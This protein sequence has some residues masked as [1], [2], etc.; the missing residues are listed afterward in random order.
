[1]FAEMAELL[2]FP[3]EEAK[4]RLFGGTFPPPLGKIKFS[5]AGL[6]GETLL[7]AEGRFPAFGPVGTLSVELPELLRLAL[8]K[9]RRR[10]AAL[11]LLFVE[12]IKGETMPLPL[13]GKPALFS[14]S[15]ELRDAL[16]WL[17]I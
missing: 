10:L 3:L 5:S 9:F 11:L 1:M 12:D 6:L 16:M 2:D 14:E 17:S 8:V 4:K 13:L 15:A 7:V